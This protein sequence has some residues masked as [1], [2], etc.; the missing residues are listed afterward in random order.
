[1]NRESASWITRVAFC[2][3]AAFAACL[4]AIAQSYPSKPVRILVPYF[5]RR[6][7]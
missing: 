4:T 1:M 3:L 7:V 5:A 6:A 2:A